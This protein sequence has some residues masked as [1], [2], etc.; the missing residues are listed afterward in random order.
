MYGI[1]RT[2]MRVDPTHPDSIGR[3][4]L[5][6]LSRLYTYYPCVHNGI[7]A[8]RYFRLY[9]LDRSGHERA[10][11]YHANWSHRTRALHVDVL[12]K[13]ALLNTFLT[14]S[15]HSAA[16][17]RAVTHAHMATH[18]LATRYNHVNSLALVLVHEPHLSDVRYL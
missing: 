11:T 10:A 17:H 18:S 9:P 2:Y 12:G 8:P 1:V 7:R 13:V 4:H 5:L 14:T 16:V 3:A 6:Q 15:T